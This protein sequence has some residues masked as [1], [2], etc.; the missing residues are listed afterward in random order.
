[1][2]NPKHVAKL[3]EGVEIWNSWRDKDLRGNP[4]LRDAWL[5]GARLSGA[6]L[7]GADLIRTQLSGARLD[8]ANL[9]GARLIEAQLIGADLRKA[10]LHG[11]DLRGSVDLRGADL[12][13]AR[14][15]GAQLSG[16]QLNGANLSGAN[17]R[18][19]NL[20]R[21]QLSN[22]DL[23]GADL[24]DA[25]LR[26]ADLHGAHL[27]RAQLIGAQLSGA[28]LSGANLSYADLRQAQLTAVGLIGVQL[29]GANL[30]NADLCGADLR[31]TFMNRVTASE[32]SFDDAKLLRFRAAG[33]DFTGAK[34]SRV[35][36]SDYADKKPKWHKFGKYEFEDLYGQGSQLDMLQMFM[37][38]NEC[39]KVF[40]SYK[41]QDD[42]H[43]NWVRQFTDDLRR[44]FDVDAQLDI[45]EVDLGQSFSD[46]MT[47]RID[48]ECMAMLFVI[49]PAAVAAVDQAQPG[50]VHFE[51]QIANARRLREENFRIIG[52]YREGTDNTA[53]L[54]DHRYIDFRNDDRYELQLEKLACS[55]WGRSDKPAL[56]HRHNG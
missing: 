9:S 45:Y 38:E 49:T 32:A 46:Y 51:M 42:T 15:I 34:C 2:A 19:V 33:C 26:E 36:F 43:N 7:S 22:A 23:N 13:D 21:A 54:K 24:T 55:L 10:N 37:S 20:Y 8:R 52:I 3:R 50:G 4:D 11:A 30:S 40:I 18:G 39:P 14:L 27:S 25:G 48:R 35:D 1:M 28:Q 6:N 47:S 56:G 17:L 31:D 53:Y 12:R 5:S 29:T 41:W 16:V 44:K